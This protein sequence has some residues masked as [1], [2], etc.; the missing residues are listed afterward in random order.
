M[1]DVVQFN[2]GSQ[3]LANPSDLVNLGAAASMAAGGTQSV[4]L[5]RLLRDGVWVFGADNTEPEEG[6]LWA[7][8]PYSFTHGFISWVD[9]KPAG[10]VMVSIMNRLPTR[11]ELPETG[12]MWDEQMG[13]QL[14]C[15]SGADKGTVVQFK[16]TSVGGKRALA[17]MATEIASHA[18]SSEDVVPVVHLNTDFYQHK[19]YGKIYTPEFAVQKWVAMDADVEAVEETEEEEAPTRRRRAR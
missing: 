18:A 14:Q 17:K 15:I 2:S 6:S 9:N 11:G 8:N 4:D 13:M 7:I 19:K 3:Q 12:G 5:L 1:N 16:T 10:E